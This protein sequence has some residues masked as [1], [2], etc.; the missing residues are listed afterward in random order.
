VVEHF[1][2]VDNDVVCV[3]PEV[4]DDEVDVRIRWSQRLDWNRRTDRVATAVIEEGEAPAVRKFQNLGEQRVRNPH[5]RDTRVDL[6]STDH[7]FVPLQIPQH[8][9][10]IGAI[11]FDMHPWEEEEVRSV[12]DLTLQRVVHSYGI[13]TVDEGWDDDRPAEPVLLEEGIEV[14]QR[15]REI[16]LGP[17]SDMD[18][19]VDD[20]HPWG[21][22]IRAH[23][24]RRISKEVINLWALPRETVI[25]RA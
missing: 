19:T 16:P 4:S 20:S 1:H 11:L 5:L 2:G 10:L 23:R 25:G 15:K 3:P 8:R 9:G 14:R 17:V 18:V 24:S 13:V 12:L 7:A 21:L 22:A 6:E